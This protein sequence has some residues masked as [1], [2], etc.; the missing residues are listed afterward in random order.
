MLGKKDM[1]MQNHLFIYRSD[2]S[3]VVS[4]L[5][6][7]SYNNRSKRM[8]SIET[9]S[10]LSCRASPQ[11]MTSY[12]RP[13]KLSAE[14]NSFVTA[15]VWTHLTFKEQ[16]KLSLLLPTE[17]GIPTSPTTGDARRKRI[18]SHGLSHW[19]PAYLPDLIFQNIPRNCLSDWSTSFLSHPLC[20]VTTHLYDLLE[21]KDTQGPCKTVSPKGGWK[22]LIGWSKHLEGRQWLQTGGGD[23]KSN[24]AFILLLKCNIFSLES[25]NRQQDRKY[26]KINL[27][28]F[29]RPGWCKCLW[30]PP[31]WG[32]P[33]T[34]MIPGK[35]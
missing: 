10:K 1:G 19:T 2:H 23:Y 22:E 15:L 3:S 7:G 29:R 17:W 11:T 5:A 32:Y 13:L 20:S 25:L 26:P 34:K 21:T 14:L 35:S 8:R 6:T 31:I 27:V 30:L 9:F 28:F 33:F 12:H 16:S 4:Y 18:S 24:Y